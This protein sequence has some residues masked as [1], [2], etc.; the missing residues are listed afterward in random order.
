M[1]GGVLSFRT[2]RTEEQ[3]YC[4]IATRSR[5]RLKPINRDEMNGT[6]RF[7]GHQ[8][9]RSS[10]KQINFIARQERHLELIGYFVPL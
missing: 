8:F 3:Q 1:L 5:P 10:L 7:N 4:A 9:H 6:D 2:L